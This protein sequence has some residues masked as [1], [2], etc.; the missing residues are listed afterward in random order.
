MKNYLMNSGGGDRVVAAENACR[1]VSCCAGA[2]VFTE[3]G[4][5]P[6][7]TGSA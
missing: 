2:S 1:L 5:M 7:S 3:K 6:A 4:R